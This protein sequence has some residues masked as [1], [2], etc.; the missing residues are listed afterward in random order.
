MKIRSLSSVLLGGALL[1]GPVVASA[2]QEGAQRH[3]IF[4]DTID[5]QLINLEV[6]AVDEDG[7]PVTDLTLEDFR[8]YE[9]GDPVEVTHF[10]AVENG[11]RQAS[12]EAIESL[13]TT[14]HGPE[15]VVPTADPGR[16][17][18]LFVDNANIH[19]SGR[20]AV[21]RQ[22][23]HD[24]DRLMAPADRVLVVSQ[25]RELRVEQ[26]FTSDYR[27]VAAALDRIERE[28][29]ADSSARL[30]EQRMIRQLIDQGREPGTDRNP[31][32]QGTDPTSGELPAAMPTPEI[33]PAMD[34][35]AIVRTIQSHAQRVALE[36]QS[37]LDALGRFVSSMAGLPGR[38]AIVY[39]SDGLEIR[40]G[41]YLFRLWDH[42]YRSVTGDLDEVR[43]RSADREIERY[44]LE[45]RFQRFLTRASSSRVTFYTIQ[46][47]GEI[48]G[49]GVSAENRRVVMSLDARQADGDRRRSMI[50]LAEATGGKAL[51]DTDNIQ[52]LLGQLRQDL[53]FYYSLGFPSPHGGDGSHHSIRVEVRRPGV[54][55]RYL[56]GY[57]AKTATER[58]EERT[59]ANLLFDVGDNPLDVRV[60]LGQEQRADRG[61]VFTVPVMIQI[62]LSNILLIPQKDAHLGRISI[63]LAVRDERGRLSPPKKID[64][65]VAVQE[66]QMVTLMS[67]NAGYLAQLL[68]RPGPQKIAVGVRDE[69]AAVASTL[70]INVDIGRN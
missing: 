14:T 45:Q 8:V 18:V 50:D 29:S 67:R 46:P 10:F 65:P 63:F 53:A 23:R 39:V 22:L 60:E 69:L 43:V 48:V 61:K 32:T 56:K 52:A 19:P 25:D 54:Q 28:S 30:A 36:T 24:L 51:T 31:P 58:M 66:D 34:A 55:L 17:F 6:T 9:D 70:Q 44:S 27:L 49:G 64:V 1:L 7:N 38:K 12:E 41:E 42:R 21:F 3:G 33:T 20:R 16:F 62:P 37:T 40:P 57:Q 11:L 2:Q 59:L 26:P 13:P 47:G 4:L 5:V 35:E 68:M 15:T